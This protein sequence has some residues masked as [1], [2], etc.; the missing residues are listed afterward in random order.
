MANPLRSLCFAALFTAAGCGG[1]SPDASLSAAP[2]SQQERVA[3]KRVRLADPD[4][5]RALFVDKGCV[6]CHA[7]NGT[8]GK[9]ASPLDAGVGEPAVDP[10][11]FAARMWRGAPA[12]IELQSTELG[13]AIDLTAAEIADLAAFAAD[14]RAQRALTPETLPEGM[15]AA[16]LDQR[17]WEIEDWE[18]RWG[19]RAEEGDAAYEGVEFEELPVD[20]D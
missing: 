6:I 12:M 17:F 20:P 16:L 2:E 5:G 7:V 8:G 4:A 18:D 10:L 3:L 15:S 9:A 14:R 19:V 1:E 13:Y 11:E